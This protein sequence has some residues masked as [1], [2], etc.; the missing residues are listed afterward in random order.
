[1]MVAV[2]LVLLLVAMAA[3]AAAAVVWQPRR[4]WSPW[5]GQERAGRGST[6]MRTTTAVDA[7]G[8]FWAWVFGAVSS[9]HGLGK[10]LAL[11][12]MKRRVR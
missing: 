9:V 7:D 1:M 11:V 5:R 6:T 8:L 2:L 4:L 10:P 3:A 12:F